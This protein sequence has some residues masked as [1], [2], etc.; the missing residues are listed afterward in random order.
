MKI[1]KRQRGFRERKE[2]LLQL[3]LDGEL[4]GRIEERESK[5]REREGFD[6]STRK[7]EGTRGSER[8]TDRLE[9]RERV[10]PCANC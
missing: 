6:Y 2:E 10:V 1:G 8:P 5:K 7:A 3:R 9:E 4:K